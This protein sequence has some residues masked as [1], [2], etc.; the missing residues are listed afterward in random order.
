MDKLRNKALKHCANWDAGKCSGCWI[1][2]EPDGTILQRINAK[3]QGK[4]CTPSKCDYY[5]TI[6]IPILNDA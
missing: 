3:L 6:V 1:R 4:E 5:E 2:C